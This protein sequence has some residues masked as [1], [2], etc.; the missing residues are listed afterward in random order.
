MNR[1]SDVYVFFNLEDKGEIKYMIYFRRIN[2]HIFIY[3][4]RERRSRPHVTA[5]VTDA[6]RTQDPFI[7]PSIQQR[8]ILRD[9]NL[10]LR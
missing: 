7:H 1:L 10:Y 2:I 8:N 4:F 3:L 9:F 6:G 5:M